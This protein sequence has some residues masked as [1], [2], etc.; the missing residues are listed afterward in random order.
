MKFQEI[1]PK[2]KNLQKI[3]E[4]WRGNIFKGEF[5]GKILAFKVPSESIHIHPILKE[6][7]ILKIVNKSG[8]GGKLVLRGEDFIAYE[9][10]EGKELR[11]II[12]K[13]NAKKILSQIL[14]QARKLDKLQ[15]T[16]EEMH[17]IHANVLVDKD[18]KVYLIDFERAKR[19]KKPKNITQF[20]QFLIT[21]GTEYLGEFDK[22]K[23]VEL[24]KNYKSS[25]T[26][27]NFL[28]IKNFFMNPPS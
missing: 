27:E 1:K 7:E 28:K 24:M 12:N 18:L 23:A 19:S 8:I 25:Q 5:E 4:G 2:I 13:Q 10:I 11:H 20:V 9:F 6:G 16:K 14:E 15:I 21:G 17:R 26:E 3:G 22:K